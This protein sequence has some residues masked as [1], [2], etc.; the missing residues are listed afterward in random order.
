MKKILA[1]VVGLSAM[2]HATVWE[3][4][5]YSDFAWGWGH[6]PT[7]SVAANRAMLECR[8][9]TPVNGVCFVDNCYIVAF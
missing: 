7:Q 6:G 4:N 9:R 5:A 3:C 2:A 8:K 1:L